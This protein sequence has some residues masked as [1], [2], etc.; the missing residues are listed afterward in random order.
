MWNKNGRELFFFSQGNLSQMRVTYNVGAV[1]PNEKPN[2]IDFDSP[3]NLF[4][5][6]TSVSPTTQP[7][8]DYSLE[9]ESFLIIEPPN[10]GDAVGRI[11]SAQTNLVVVENIFSELSSLVRVD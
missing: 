3:E 5:R 1:G 7:V 9:R 11:L 6:V 2:L 8:W 10:V 4:T